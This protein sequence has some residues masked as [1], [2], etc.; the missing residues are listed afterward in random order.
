MIELS[1]IEKYYG[2]YHALRDVSC[3]IKKG[4]FFSLLGPSGSGKTTLLRA[5][6]GFEGIDSGAVMIGGQSMAGVP[7]NKRPTN[8]VFQSYA[9]FPHM[10]VAQNVAYGLRAQRLSKTQTAE[11]VNKSLDKVGLAGYGERAAHAL[12]GGQRQRVALARALILKPKVL[13]LDEPLSALDRKLREEMQSELR[14]LQRSLGITF[15]LV[16]HDQEEA[17][18]MSDR[19]AV[20]FEGQIAQLGTPQSLYKRPTSKRVAQFFGSMNIL[21]AEVRAAQN[22]V[23]ITQIEGLGV[24]EIPQ[25][26][27]PDIQGSSVCVGVRPELMTVLDDDQDAYDKETPA[28]VTDIEYR[29]ELTYYDVK[30]EGLD[31]PVVVSMRNTTNREIKKIGQQVRIGWENASAVLLLDQ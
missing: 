14:H 7:P 26:L 2:D 28:V 5:I 4:E 13:L 8:M 29:G 18:T 11:M 21:K 24:A 3:Q 22:G 23:V 20:M 16:T 30:F 1:N 27:A 25:D 6:A 31:T 9:I 17:L 15:V 19:V 12:S 10:N